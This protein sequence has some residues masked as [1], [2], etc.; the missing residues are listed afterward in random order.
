MPVQ[1]GTEA[2]IKQHNTVTTLRKLKLKKLKRLNL[3]KSRFV[4]ILMCWIL[5]ALAALYAFYV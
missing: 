2:A 1:V 5:A 3:E 4:S